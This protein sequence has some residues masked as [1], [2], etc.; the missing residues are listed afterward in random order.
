MDHCEIEAINLHLLNLLSFKLSLFPNKSLTKFLVYSQIFIE[1]I[2]LI[3]NF[4]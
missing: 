2:I 4:S 3:F 1:Q